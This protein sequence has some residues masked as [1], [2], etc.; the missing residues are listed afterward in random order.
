MHPYEFN[1]KEYTRDPSKL[2][3]SVPL[4]YRDAFV[5]PAF[6]KA[7]VKT[8][9]NGKMQSYAYTGAPA[10]SFMFS[11]EM[12]VTFWKWV[13]M[14]AIV[15]VNVIVPSAV[16][17]PTLK[18]RPVMP[19]SVIVP[20]VAV[21]VTWTE[22]EAA[23]TS[24]M[25]IWLELPL[26]KT[27]AVSSLVLWAAGTVLTGASFTALTVMATESVSDNE[28]Q[29]LVAVTVKTSNAGAAE[30][31]PRAWRMKITVQKVG[32]EAKVAN[33]RFVA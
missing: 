18:L 3:I 13:L 24:L 4:K 1:G 32:D 11:K 16:P 7:E 25:L 15:P 12:G 26:E 21:S 19:L 27:S 14:F 31:E 6:F 8:D 5:L 2:L 29:V 30:Q 10:F 9:D 23:S 28:A 33:V 17:S 20:L 22:D